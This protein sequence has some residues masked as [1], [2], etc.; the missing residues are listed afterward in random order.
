VPLP[1]R[2]ATAQPPAAASRWPA[3]TPHVNSTL[4]PL[5]NGHRA[6]PGHDVGDG[7]GPWERP[8]SVVR[9]PSS[10]SLSPRPSLWR[11]ATCLFRSSRVM[12]PARHELGM[13]VQSMADVL[14]TTWG[15]DRDFSKHTRRAWNQRQRERDDDD[16]Q[17]EK[18]PETSQSID[19]RA[20]SAVPWPARRPGYAAPSPGPA[21]PTRRHEMSRTHPLP[22]RMPLG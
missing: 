15:G 21:P 6:P 19:T 5:P 4:D 11:S 12:C 9:R 10:S 3:T 8:S 17:P 20:S 16:A 1:L 22:D 14:F 7:E 18:E 2:R 13:P